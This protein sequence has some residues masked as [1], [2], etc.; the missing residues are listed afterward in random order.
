M[1]FLYNTLHYYDTKLRDRPL[2]KR[3]LVNA[4]LGS[5]KDVRPAGWA[6]TDTFQT[7]LTKP[8]VEATSWAPELNYYLTL[9]KRMVDSILYITLLLFTLLLT[10]YQ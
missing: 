7:Y 6:T 4:V 5:L 2:L 10:T 1:T 3:K 9:V 8:D